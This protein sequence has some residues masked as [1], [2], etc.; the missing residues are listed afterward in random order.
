[1][2]PDSQTCVSHVE[3][4]PN[5][6]PLLRWF[7]GWIPPT[8]IREFEGAFEELC[9][10]NKSKIFVEAVEHALK[11]AGDF[12]PDGW[13]AERVADKPPAKVAKKAAEPASIYTA[14]RRGEA[15]ANPALMTERQQLKMLGV[16][17]DGETSSSEEEEEEEEEDEVDKEAKERKEKEKEE[18]RRLREEKKEARRKE[19]EERKEEERREEERKEKEKEDKRKAAAEEKKKAAASAAAA[20]KKAKADSETGKAGKTAEKSDAAGGKKGPREKA[21]AR[22]KTPSAGSKLTIPEPDLGGIDSDSE[23]EQ[24]QIEV[25]EVA[26]EK[27]AAA[28]VSRGGGKD[29]EKNRGGGNAVIIDDDEEGVNDDVIMV[30]KEGG[31][32]ESKREREGG[33]ADKAPFDPKKRRLAEWSSNTGGG[34]G[35]HGDSSN[36]RGGSGGAAGENSAVL[37]SRG[38]DVAHTDASAVPS[39]AGNSGG[40]APVQSIDLERCRLFVGN[41]P[42][43]TGNSEMTNFCKDVGVPRLKDV[44]IPQ[45]KRFGFVRLYTWDA[46]VKAKELLLE[47]KFKGM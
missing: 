24:G 10:K 9:K 8:K 28:S 7:Y 6:F 12:K 3:Q 23:E 4:P 47:N 45:G 34:E 18:K 46:T 33:E 38:G 30:D 39:D 27:K 21:T 13:T 15:V 43:G 25:Q 44:R 17:V 41:L 35:G 31:G 37:E 11:L 26:P 1:M 36:E 20:A 16:K 32:G 5:S 29:R 2:L 42:V 14:S 22:V 19:R 40:A